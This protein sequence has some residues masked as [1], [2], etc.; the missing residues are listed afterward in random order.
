VEGVV[1]K[2]ESVFE[3]A[4]PDLPPCLTGRKGRFDFRKE[5]GDERGF[6][7]RGFSSQFLQSVAVAIC[8]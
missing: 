2:I 6:R 5:D 4:L 8:G 7:G 3:E 1:A